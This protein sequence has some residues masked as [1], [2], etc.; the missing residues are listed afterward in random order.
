LL[1]AA[2]AL[3]EAG[4]FALVLEC[5]PADLAAE[6]TA[7][8]SIPTIGI[9]AGPGCLGQVLVYHDLLGVED[10]MA[11]RFVRRYA[12]QGQDTRRALA[13]FAGDVRTGAF[14]TA[15]ESFGE[16]QTRREPVLGKLYG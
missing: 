13:A 2:L 16:I 9:G 4:A 10:R 14:P 8:L 3:E 12:Q 11:P 7:A 1:T 6:V 5:I 15:A